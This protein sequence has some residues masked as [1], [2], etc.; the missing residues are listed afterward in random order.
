MDGRGETSAFTLVELLVVIAIIAVL[1]ALLLPALSSA[2]QKAWTI[3]CASN[4]RQIGIGLESFASDNS[5]R[6]P[7]SGGRIR[8]NAI[9]PDSPTNGWM[10]QIFAVVANTNV[11]HC[12]GNARLPVSHQSPFNYFNGTR[13]AYVVS[14]PVSPHFAAVTQSAIRFTSAFVLSG[15]TIDDAQYFDRDDCDK[16]DYT[17]NCVGGAA[18]GTPAVQ[19]QAHKWGQN[20]LFADGHARWYRRYDAADMTFRYDS[21]HGWQ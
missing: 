20:I 19:W 21:M 4:L 13:A 12:P 5:E 15:D 1:A 10:Q 11:F 8:W 14:D 2:K 18:N 9:E 16:D 3:S 6:Y 17:Q 7:M